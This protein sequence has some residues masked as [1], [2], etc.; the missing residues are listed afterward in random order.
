M[1]RVVV[2][3]NC[4]MAYHLSHSLIH[5][6]AF[7]S[8]LRT[9]VFAYLYVDIF[10]VNILFHTHAREKKKKKKMSGAESVCVSLFSKVFQHFA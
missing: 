10:N 9:H 2:M 5:F 7:F 6:R 4:E 3:P 1:T 8:L